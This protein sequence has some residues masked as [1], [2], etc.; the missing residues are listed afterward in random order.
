[1]DN[2]ADWSPE[3][4]P[5]ATFEGYAVGLG[6]DLNQF[7]S[8][9]ADP[10]LDERVTRDRDEAEG[11]GIVSTPSFILQNEPLAN[12]GTVEGFEQAIND[13]LSAL[14][15]P[16]TIDRRTGQIILRDS[17]LLDNANTP[18]IT[19]AILVKDSNGNEEVVTVTIEVEP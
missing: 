9:V 15:S 1:M 13:Q 19:L 8:D 14:T 16:V 17:T 6:L 5:T 7:R 2:Q 4:D 11:L 10:A 3:S 18:E 12:P